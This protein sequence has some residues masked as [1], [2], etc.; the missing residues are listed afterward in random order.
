[1]KI[2]SINKN[3]LFIL[4]VS[5]LTLSITINV[6]AKE[7][8]T[9]KTNIKSCYD[10]ISKLTIW[11]V[12]VFKMKNGGTIFAVKSRINKYLLIIIIISLICNS[13]QYI[14]HKLEANQKQ[15]SSEI[16]F[17]MY[18]ESTYDNIQSLKTSKYNRVVNVC[19][20]GYSLGKVCSLCQ[21]TS[22][23]NK[24]KNLLPSLLALKDVFANNSRLDNLLDTKDFNELLSCLNKVKNSPLDEKV[25]EDLY[26]ISIKIR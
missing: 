15:K 7:N 22:Y 17:I 19:M 1:M 3:L 26:N 4:L 24:N 21:M 2:K 8:V 13:F 18:L 25:A 10:F 11:R 6:Q 12:I 9:A 23:N 5:I 20:L 16:D 14:S